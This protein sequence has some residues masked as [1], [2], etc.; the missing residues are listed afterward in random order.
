[1][2]ENPNRTD[3]AD[4]FDAFVRGALPR[5]AISAER[6]RSVID[7]TLTR[8]GA[9]PRGDSACTTFDGVAAALRATYPFVPQFPVPVVAAV[10]L[11]IYVGKA[12]AVAPPLDALVALLGYHQIMP[13]GF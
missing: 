12:F 13:V 1:M 7:G 2:T 9:M 6:L 10:A 3:D 5:P 11:G 4:R 8:T